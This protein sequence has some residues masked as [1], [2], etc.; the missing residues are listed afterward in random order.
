MALRM[1]EAFFVL[2]VLV[3]V[4]TWL[5]KIHVF[6]LSKAYIFLFIREAFIDALSTSQDKFYPV[7]HGYVARSADW[8]YSSIHRDIKRGWSTADCAAGWRFEPDMC[9]EW[10]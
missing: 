5:Y 7:K 8:C 1:P 9:G 6:R 3:V 4:P 10:P 2:A